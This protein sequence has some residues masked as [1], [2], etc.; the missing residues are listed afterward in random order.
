MKTRIPSRMCVKRLST[1]PQHS[2]GSTATLT[3][4]KRC[5]AVYGALCI[6][7]RS[8]VTYRCTAHQMQ[9][10]YQLLYNNYVEDD[11]SM[12]RFDYSKAFL[13]WALK[14]PGYLKT[15]HVGVRLTSNKQLMGFIAA[16]PCDVRV[17]S[18]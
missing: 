13:K 14:P 18:K 5:V 12:F 6:Y 8:A 11:D 7:I 1:Y 9:D 10:I 4:T 2:S 3:T 17:H 16:I 15:W